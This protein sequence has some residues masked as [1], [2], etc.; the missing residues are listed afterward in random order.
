MNAIALFVFA[1]VFSFML[2]LRK[3]EPSKNIGSFI[4]GIDE[5]VAVE[6]AEAKPQQKSTWLSRLEEDAARAGLNVPVRNLLLLAVLGSTAGFT[7]LFAV[8]NSL[9]LGMVGLALGF[10][11]PRQYIRTLKKR[12]AETFRAQFNGVLSILSSSLRAGSS[13]EQALQRAA[14]DAPSPARDELWRAVQTMKLG[15]PPEDA[16]LELKKRI[17][18]PEVDVFVVATQI[19]SRTGGNIAEIYD[20]IGQMVLERKAFRQ[21]LRAYTSQGRLSATV[22][23]VLPILVTAF[24][25]L[26]NPAYFRPLTK[27]ALGRVLLVVCYGL[28]ALGW[29]V[30]NRMIQISL[31]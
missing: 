12:R 22:V 7:V 2:S 30:I 5:R 31:D 20:L 19:L 21:A 8:T 1:S 11:L 9:L 15:L 3:R 16:V 29:W 18:C 27:S 14:E 13:L 28:M 17:D 10:V 6:I 24:L 23:S 26:Q 25:Y 4:M